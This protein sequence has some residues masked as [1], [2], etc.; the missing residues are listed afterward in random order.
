[1]QDI[2]FSHFYRDQMKIRSPT[3]ANP[4]LDNYRVDILNFINSVMAGHSNE[5]VIEQGSIESSS[6]IA[7]TTTTTTISTTTTSISTIT[8]A[9]LYFDGEYKPEFSYSIVK[10]LVLSSH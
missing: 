4:T 9:S 8:S 3:L 10:I 1:M 6:T 5:V 2:F 7:T